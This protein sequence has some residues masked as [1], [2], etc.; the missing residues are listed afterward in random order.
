MPIPADARLFAV[1]PGAGS[2]ER[3]AAGLPKQYL[4]LR[5]S[6]LAEQ[7]LARLLALGRIERIAVPV[8][9]ND[10][11]WPE[12]KVASHARILGCTGGASRALSVVAG[13]EAL[14]SGAGARDTDWVLVHDMARPCIRLSD[15]ERL[16]HACGSNGAILALP[17]TDTIKHA[18]AEQQIEITLD[19]SRIWRALTPQLFAI[20]PLLD[21]LQAGLSRAPAQITDEASAM[22][23]AGV[24]PLLV[25][26]RSDNIKVT[27]PDDLP[28]ADFY[29]ARQEQEALQWQSA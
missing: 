26:G 3:M 5:G 15:I 2:G 11:W 8:A 19:R 17:V 18:D 16:L 22:E 23:M 24:H 12:L 21:A 10:P 7:T 20:G 28:L 9:D 25:A 27:L 4:T 6:T 13:L 14:K 1:V 29:L